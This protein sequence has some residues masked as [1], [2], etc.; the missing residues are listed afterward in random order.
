MKQ[1]THFVW[2]DPATGDQW[3]ISNAAE[4]AKGNP[5]RL[6]LEGAPNCGDPAV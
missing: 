4:L 6:P 2:L 1:L 5:D 3:L